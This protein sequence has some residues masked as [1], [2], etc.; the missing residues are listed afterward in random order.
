[1]TEQPAL[2]RADWPRPLR[3]ARGLITGIAND[4]SIAYAVAK[5][6]REARADLAITYQNEKTAGYTRPLAA[7]LEAKLFVKL[8]VSEPGAIENVID[9]SAQALG[10]LD[11]VIHSMAFCGA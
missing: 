2:A 5:A 11:F 8:D 7:G 1:M 3:A 4:H 10:G 9:E 6:A